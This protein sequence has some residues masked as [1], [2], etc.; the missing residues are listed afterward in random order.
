MAQRLTEHQ[1]AEP[2]IIAIIQKETILYY[3]HFI[4]ARNILELTINATAQHA[5]MLHSKFY[6]SVHFAKMLLGYN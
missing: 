6:L 4:K 5:S 2:K 1:N 3:H